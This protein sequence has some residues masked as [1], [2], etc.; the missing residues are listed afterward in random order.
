MPVEERQANESYLRDRTLPML[1][2]AAHCVYLFSND[3]FGKLDLTFQQA[4]V[5]IFIHHNRGCNQ[6][7]VEQHIETRSASVTVLLNTMSAKGLILK[8]RNPVD[9]RG[10]ILAVTSKGRRL[11]AKCYQV[12]VEVS[13]AAF[14]G[15][16]EDDQET[17]KRLLR[18][19]AENCSRPTARSSRRL[20][21][22]H[23]DEA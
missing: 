15:M 7:A 16:S 9:G 5:L 4:V 10:V 3:L 21:P 20:K 23:G 2:R 6:R 17:L 18:V 12:F 19:M 22:E 8:T 11:A 1:H 14:R 13:E